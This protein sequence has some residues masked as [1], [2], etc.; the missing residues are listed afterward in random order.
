LQLRFW[1]PETGNHKDNALVVFNHNESQGRQGCNFLCS[2]S[3]KQSILQGN[4]RAK[5]E[6]GDGLFIYL[7]DRG[8]M[9]PGKESQ[10][11]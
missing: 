4:T 5:N 3:G 11:F 8:A 6:Q 1:L 9:S 7:L 2:D 10:V